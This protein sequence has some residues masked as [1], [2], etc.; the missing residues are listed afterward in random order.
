M[1]L[2]SLLLTQFIGRSESIQTGMSKEHGV[3]NP[4]AQLSVFLEQVLSICRII[5]LWVMQHNNII[6]REAVAGLQEW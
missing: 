3:H 2:P 4:T 5:M 6:E 1:C